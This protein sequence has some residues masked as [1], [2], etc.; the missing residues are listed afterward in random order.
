[1]LFAWSLETFAASVQFLSH[2]WSA[3]HGHVEGSA[4]TPELLRTHRRLKAGVVF[5]Q[6]VRVQSL[7]ACPWK[8]AM[9]F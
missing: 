5:L 7:R 8:S 4:L 9:S 1:M 6:P 3:R 2:R